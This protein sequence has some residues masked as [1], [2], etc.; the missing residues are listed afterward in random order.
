MSSQEISGLKIAQHSPTLSHLFFAD[1]TLIFY[2]ANKEEADKV[3]KLWKMYGKAL[4]QVINAEKSSVFFST[5]TGDKVKVEILDILGGMKE[6]RQSKYLGLPLVIGRPK[7]QVFN[8]IRERVINRMCGWKER[9]LSNAGKE[10]LLKSVILALPAYAMS[11]CK[12]P[13]GEYTVKTGYVVAKELQRKGR[14]ESQQQG[15]SSRN[16]ANSGVWRFL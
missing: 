16:D 2:K 4:G 8:Y 5:N 6:A 13:K 14:R 10:V 15:S 11:C 7:K 12:L 3:M 9:L 1:N